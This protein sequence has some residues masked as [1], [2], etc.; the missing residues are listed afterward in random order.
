MIRHL[1]FGAIL[2]LVLVVVLPSSRTLRFAIMIF[3]S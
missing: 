1:A 3:C 2:V